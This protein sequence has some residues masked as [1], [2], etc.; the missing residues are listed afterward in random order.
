MYYIKSKRTLKINGTPED[1]YIAKVYRGTDITQ[2]ELCQ[3]IAYAS[4]LTEGDVNN[5]LKQFL[6]FIQ[7]HCAEGRAVQTQIGKFIPAIRSKAVRTVDE[8]DNSTI[9]RVTCRFYPSARFKNN[10]KSAPVEFKD[11][12]KIKYY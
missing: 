10:M 11:L 12:S 4:S 8:V 7:R 5:C 9:K 3:E 6:F 2:E 1:R